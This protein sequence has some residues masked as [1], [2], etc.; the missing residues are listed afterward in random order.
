MHLVIVEDVLALH[1]EIAKEHGTHA[2][3]LNRGGVEAAIERAEWGPFEDGDLAERAAFLLR[4]IAQD[5]PFVD[6]NKR[7]AF[8]AAALLLERNSVTLDAR[9]EE[10]VAFMLEVAQGWHTVG[11]I[12][13]WLRGKAGSLKV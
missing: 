13:A 11:S 12:A 10:V 6:G 4:G 2:G 7:T 3:I 1:A 5:H 8:S 9:P